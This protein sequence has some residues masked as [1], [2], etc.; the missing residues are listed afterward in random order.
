ML[1]YQRDRVLPTVSTRSHRLKL[2]DS[3]TV[4]AFMV[5]I[6]MLKDTDLAGYLDNLGENPAVSSEEVR[7]IKWRPEIPQGVR[8]LRIS[9]YSVEE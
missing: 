6:A 5:G 4:L 7:K 8:E 9:R 3:M 1:D 2:L